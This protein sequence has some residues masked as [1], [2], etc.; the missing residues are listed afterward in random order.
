MRAR[1]GVG[2]PIDQ[3]SIPQLSLEELER[4]FRSPA[5]AR[6]YKNQLVEVVGTVVYAMK[7]DAQG[8]GGKPGY[9]VYLASAPGEEAV[10]C[11]SLRG[12]KP[13]SVRIGEEAVLQGKVG[14]IEYEGPQKVGL[15]DAAVVPHLPE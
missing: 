12:E 7:L 6:R 5:L 8:E 14:V 4:D 13:P 15:V 1:L 11:C 9:L 2:A 10:V 3:S